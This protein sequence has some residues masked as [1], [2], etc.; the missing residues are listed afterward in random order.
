M[1]FG[2]FVEILPGKEGL[3][4]ISKMSK[5]RVAQV[6]DVVKEGDEIQV[7]IIEVDK[8]G[9]INLTM[10]D[11]DKDVSAFK[12]KPAGGR[13]GE[14]ERPGPGPWSRWTRQVIHLD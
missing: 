2:A 13:G 14:T 12:R 1:D 11:L 9:R 5:E 7:K 10:I 3:V 6:S 4:H 8:M